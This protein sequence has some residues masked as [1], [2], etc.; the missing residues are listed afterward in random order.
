MRIKK[1][2]E[3][4]K[5]HSFHFKIFLGI[6]LAV[7]ISYLIFCFFFMHNLFRSSFTQSLNTSQAYAE[8]VTRLIEANAQSLRYHADFVTLDTDVTEILSQ[9]HSNS[10][11]NIIEWMPDYHIISDRINL[12]YV[13]SGIHSLHII[14]ENDF[15]SQYDS[16]QLHP[17]E[18]CQDSSWYK[19][20]STSKDSFL[21]HTAAAM[22]EC[23]NVTDNYICFTRHL[24]IQYNTYETYFVGIIEREIF[25]NLLVLDNSVPFCY[26]GLLNA[27]SDFITDIPADYQDIF[28]QI[29]GQLYF[30]AD[31]SLEKINIGKHAYYATKANIYNTDLTFIYLLDYQNMFT[32]ML[33]ASLHT[34]FLF[35]MVLLPFSIVISYFLSRSLSQRIAALKNNMLLAS[36][37]NFNLPILSGNGEDEISLLNRHFNYMLTKISQLMDEQY[38]NGQRIKELELI[39]LQAQINPH[40]LY[41]TLDLIKWKAVRS[42]D[43]ET[44]ELINALSS[45]YRL[46]LSKGKDIVPLQSELE[47]AKAYVF[48]QNKRFDDSITLHID[49]PDT[50]LNYQVPKLLLQPIVENAILHGILELPEAMGDIWI[51]A[52]ESDQFFILSIHDNGIGIA[53]HTPDTN[54]TG[55][56]DDSIPAIIKTGYGLKNINNR[57]QLA[58]GNAYGLII[59][60]N[61]TEGTTISLHF[62]HPKISEE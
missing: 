2:Y 54:N 16:T 35:L 24:P 43:T 12:S 55:R 8:R 10:Y 34:L 58:F 1:H 50:Y 27:G 9:N 38:S 5:L 30:Q 45:Y 53:E 36:K 61:I 62:P 37:G 18:M 15:A 39:S 22:P 26:C 47:H 19:Q 33:Y 4:I 57:I 31:F 29:N 7:F 49:V 59:E 41:N 23:L 3:H 13:N 20:V 56:A 21:F 14:T 48:I 44:E 6:N 11:Q 17:L 32:N 28:H 40:F 25:N 42:H 46:S 52:Q 60:P 51:T